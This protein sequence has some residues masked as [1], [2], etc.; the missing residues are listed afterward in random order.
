MCG[1]VNIR[2]RPPPIAII[3]FMIQGTT[4]EAEEGMTWGEWVESEYN[5]INAYAQYG[6][7][8]LT[9][10]MRVGGEG[11]TYVST[12]SIIIENGTY[13]PRSGGAN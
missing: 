7:V 9:A 4:Y 1:M 3:E 11:E 13:Y 5:T 8:F 2:G 6:Q 12:T 10:I